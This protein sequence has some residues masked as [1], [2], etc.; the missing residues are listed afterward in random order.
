MEYNHYKY[1]KLQ[2]LLYRRRSR[3]PLLANTYSSTKTS[4]FTGTRT[5]YSSTLLHSKF[6]KTRNATTLPTVLVQVPM[7]CI[8]SVLVLCRTWYKYSTLLVLQIK[9]L[10]W[11]FGEEYTPEDKRGHAD[12]GQR[13]ARMLWN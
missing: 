11:K 7:Y 8:L 10:E 4:N 6:R 9:F 2:S 12:L 1:S 5:W 3:A 13:E